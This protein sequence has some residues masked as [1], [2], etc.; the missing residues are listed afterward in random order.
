MSG[1]P[2]AE[3]WSALALP[4]RAFAPCLLR[5]AVLWDALTRGFGF[6]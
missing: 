1:R 4:C 3:V 2:S 5:P 6:E